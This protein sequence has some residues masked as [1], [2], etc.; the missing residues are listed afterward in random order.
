MRLR[1]LG[2]IGISLAALL[3]VALL[4]SA[5]WIFHLVS[6]PYKGFPDR[7][8]LVTIPKGTSVPGIGRTLHRAGVIRHPVLFNWYVRIRYPNSSLKAGEYMFDRPYSLQEVSVKLLSGE[9]YARRVTVPEGLNRS[10]IVELLVKSGMGSREGFEK[11]TGDP[12]LIFHLDPLAENLEGY[13]FP[14]T[15]FFSSGTREKEI[16]KTLVSEF[17]KCWT[18][19]RQKMASELN[20]SVR[21]VVTLASIVEKETALPVERPLVSAVFHNRLRRNMPLASDPTI[22]YG[23]KL[24]KEYDGVINQS[25][26]KLDSPYNTYVY[27]GLPPGPIAS[28]G[29]ASIDAALQPADVN[30]LFFVSRNDGSHLFSEAYRD[31]ARAV[32]KYQR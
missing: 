6:Q 2:R 7:E 11:A 30:Y 22:I 12:Q 32:Q 16:V 24:I 26:L 15:F 4:A 28:P 23:V 5:L 19:E 13:L 27:N 18:P 31:H 25:D 1:R 14:N 8:L 17:L 10:E 21:E 20:M 9:V 3:L 29:L